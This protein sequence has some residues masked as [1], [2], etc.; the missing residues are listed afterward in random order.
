MPRLLPHGLQIGADQ[1]GFAVA[2]Y[3]FSKR[4]P[5]FPS[6]LGE[7]AVIPDLQF[8]ADFVGLLE[9][10]VEVT[11][12]EN[13]SQLDLNGPENLILVEART[14]RLSDLGEQFVL[15]G[16]AVRI[17][18]HY[19][20]FQGESQ[21]QAQAHHQ[22]RTGRTEGLAFGVREQNHAEVMLASLQV[23]R[24]QIPDIRF[25]ENPLEFRE[26]S[27]RSPPGEVRSSPPDPAP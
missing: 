16:A 11:G 23:D 15:F 26:R 21:L 7:H 3:V 27:H 12:I 20:V 24:G 13:L 22:P 18:T 17:V 10:D 6:A 2:D 14:D 9:R 25:G 4:I 5:Q 8:E 1:Q 19:V